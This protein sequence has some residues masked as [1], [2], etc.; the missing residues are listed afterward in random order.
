MHEQGL[1]S[2]VRRINALTGIAA[3]AAFEA[4]N[5]LLKQIGDAY[6]LEGDALVSAFETLSP[7]LDELTIS[8]T[9]KHEAKQLLTPLLKKVKSLQKEASSSLRDQ[10]LEQAKT[11]A[12]SEEN[13]VVASIDNADKDSMM[14]ALDVV[15]S[16]RPEGAVMLFGITFDEKVLITAGVGKTMMS[17]GLKAGDWVREAAKVCGGGGGGRADTAQAGGKLPAK[18]PEAI[19]QAI[20]FAKEATT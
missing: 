3:K 17:Q 11:I 20:A 7:L 14:T 6:T 4:G 15:R 18:V 2:G 5:S 16:S 9:A 13:I 12:Q 8:Q 1:A 10:V 19:D